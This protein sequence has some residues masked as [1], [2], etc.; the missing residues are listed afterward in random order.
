MELHEEFRV[1]SFVCACLRIN[2][3]MDSRKRNLGG[4]KELLELEIPGVNCKDTR[5]HCRCLEWK[6]GELW[7]LLLKD[8]TLAKTMECLLTGGNSKELRGLNMLDHHLDSEITSGHEISLENNSQ[9]RAKTVTKW[10]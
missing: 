9:L 7:L 2:V 1:T 6:H 4:L 5:G 8:W 10:E 3:F